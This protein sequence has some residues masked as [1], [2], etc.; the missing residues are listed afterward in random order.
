MP[1]SQS[2]AGQAIWQA[3]K[4]APGLIAGGAVDVAN[5]ALGLLS[6]KG[7]SGLS[8][9]PVGGGDWI[10]EQF[11]MTASKDALQQGTEA[12]LSMMSPGG[13][14]KAII[15]GLPAKLAKDIGISKIAEQ[16]YRTQATTRDRF[17]TALESQQALNAQR[18]PEGIQS[19]FYGPDGKLRAVVS[20]EQARIAAS[21]PVQ[22][23]TGA[24]VGPRNTSASLRIDP[25]IPDYTPFALSDFLL[26]PNMY[27]LVPELAQAKVQVNP[28]LDMFGVL[29]QVNPTTNL[30]SLP[31]YTYGSAPSAA[32]PLGSL[33][34]T[35]LHE[36]GHVAQSA[37]GL[38]GGSAPSTTMLLDSLRE[39]KTKGSFKNLNTLDK[40]TKLVEGLVANKGPSGMAIS[41][42]LKEKILQ[43]LYTTNYGEWEARAGAAYAPQ[44]LPLMYERKQTW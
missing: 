1:N 22:G 23:I 14:A 27:N 15:I 42:Q 29:G 32:D 13:M 30:I 33:L 26:H 39:A 36:S 4:R 20:N 41:P 10:N 16:A 44:T 35:V 19:L 12:A 6:G 5:L 37:G 43:D 34:N 28:I 24:T 21:A 31:R 8:A 11:G 2:P 9:K 40:M 25:A 3:V 7:L 38:R 17:K 18:N